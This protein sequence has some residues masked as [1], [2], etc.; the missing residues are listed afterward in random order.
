[1]KQKRFLLTVLSLV[2]VAAISIAGTFAYLTDRDSKANVFTL[3]DVRIELHEN[4]QQGAKLIPGVDIEKTPTITNK[5]DNDAWVWLTFSIP[6]AL[7]N[8]IQGTETGSNENVIHWNPLGATTEGYVND[9]RVNTAIASGYLDSSLT[10]EK[11]LQDNMT[12]NVFNSINQGENVYKE[13]FNGIEYNTYVLLYNKA[14]VKGETTLPSIYKVFLDAQVDIDPDGNW[15][16]VNNGVVTKLN[17]NSNTNGAPVIYV[18]AYA[19]QA[20]GFATVKEAY[21]AY[22][23]QWGSNGIA[24]PE[25]KVE[26]NN[27]ASILAAIDNAA[28]G[29]TV[30]LT[31]DVTISGYAATEKLVINKNVVLDLNGNTITTESGWGGIDL[32]GGASIINGTIN[33]TGNTAAIKAFQVEKIENVT[34][35]LTET[36][37]KTKGGI[38]LQEGNGCY[39]GSIKNVVIN[40]ATNGIECY[41][42]TNDLA[43]GSME[44]VKIN[45]TQNGIYL[46]GAGKIGKISNCEINGGNIGINAYLANL[47]NISLDIENSKI[48][49]G[50]SGIDIWDENATNSGSTI[51][52]NY[53]TSSNFIGNTNN[54]KITLQEEITCN[55]NGVKQ[56]TPCNIY[57]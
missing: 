9:T 43:I 42:S 15:S 36:V 11:I 52:F 44:N 2:L 3:G 55:I 50:V 45:A 17:W 31:E 27:K 41:R 19:I 49:G 46:N 57:N 56:N 40:G 1:M 24:R 14:L 29:S 10:A 54:I 21:A 7:D 26:G 23:K 5:G 51:T 34:I 22:G 4:F 47:W 33:H 53:D 32:K 35:N 38:V 48:S 30:V 39:I 12:W 8:Y 16:K 6:S 18:S 20:D 28:P 13:D 25:T 37:G